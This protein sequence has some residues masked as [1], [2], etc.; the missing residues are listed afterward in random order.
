M[1]LPTGTSSK[2]E[3]LFPERSGISASP[4][5]KI[6]HPRI[7]IFMFRNEDHPCIK[8]MSENVGW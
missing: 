3:R 7:L 1:K 4:L 6:L 5:T 8:A 2:M